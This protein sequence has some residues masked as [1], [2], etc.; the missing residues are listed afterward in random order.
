[1]LGL[2]S[3]FELWSDSELF[4]GPTLNEPSNKHFIQV[5]QG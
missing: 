4:C 1:M 3:V 2:Q 5:I